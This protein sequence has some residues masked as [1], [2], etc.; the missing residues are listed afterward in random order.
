V[1]RGMKFQGKQPYMSRPLCC[2]A[3]LHAWDVACSLC[4]IRKLMF[5]LTRSSPCRKKSESLL[6]TIV[7]NQFDLDRGLYSASTSIFHGTYIRHYYSCTSS[8]FCMI[9]DWC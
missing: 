3:K 9:D 1:Q 8:K 7:G 2:R 4:A 6:L 5:K